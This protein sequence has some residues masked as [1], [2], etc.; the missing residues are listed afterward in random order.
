VLARYIDGRLTGWIEE[1]VEDWLGLTINREK[2][3]VVNVRE[4]GQSLD[5]LG[6]TFRY[7]RDLR[8]RPHRYLNVFPSKTAVAR[9]RDR[10]R[11][12]ISPRRSH[13]PLPH[14]IDDLNRHLRGWANYFSFGY[15]RTALR[16]RVNS[17]VRERLTRHCKRRSQRPWRPPRGESAYAHFKRTGLLYL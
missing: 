2:T 12:L 7:D 3:R 17:Y 8:G 13:M 10:L 9:E 1:T 16:R 14:Q 5:F 6:Y 15:P 11:E 4:P